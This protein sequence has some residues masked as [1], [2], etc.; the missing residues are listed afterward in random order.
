[1]DDDIVSDIFW[2]S[3]LLIIVVYFAGF[4]SDTQT[5]ASS[6]TSLINV[7]TGRNAAGQFANYPGGAGVATSLK[8]V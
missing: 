8:A 4:V 6:L 5:V 7:A 1:M 3:I 2:L